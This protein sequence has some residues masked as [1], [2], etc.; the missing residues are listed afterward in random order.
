MRDGTA[1]VV[2]VVGTPGVDIEA[3]SAALAEMGLP[4]ASHRDAL[5]AIEQ[6]D[7]ERRDEATAS[8]SEARR[9]FAD[10]FGDQSRAHWCLSAGA[11][12][13]WMG[14][15]PLAPVLLALGVIPAGED[16]AAEWISR[17]VAVLATDPLAR[18][19]DYG[20]TR[21]D[22]QRVARDVAE[23][24]SLEYTASAAAVLERSAAPDE[25]DPPS[26]GVIGRRAR[27]VRGLLLDAPRSTVNAV[28]DMLVALDR[29]EVSQRGLVGQIEAHQDALSTAEEAAEDCQKQLDALRIELSSARRDLAAAESSG[30]RLEVELEEMRF[31]LGAAE[32]RAGD[33]VARAAE[34]ERRIKIATTPEIVV[35]DDES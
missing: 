23:A 21:D 33:A 24:L 9:L 15:V 2:P 32:R 16:G 6:Y 31:R 7:H 35:A 25:A 1:E 34:L 19:I 3:L 5:A 22:P 20:Q 13:G 28:V 8:A 27:A 4:T 29:A 10:A 14:A 30:D 26:N 11:F 17:V 18:V 12:S